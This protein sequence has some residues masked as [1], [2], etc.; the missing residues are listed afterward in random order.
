MYALFE[1]ETKL[2]DMETCIKKG[3]DIPQKHKMINTAVNTGDSFVESQ[4]KTSHD[5]DKEFSVA[6]A[7]VKEVKESADWLANIVFFQEQSLL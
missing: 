1:Q 2:F 4:V 7:K 5:S 3:W 6:L